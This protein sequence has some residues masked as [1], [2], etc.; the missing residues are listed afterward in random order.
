MRYRAAHA[1]GLNPGSGNEGSLPTVV[2]KGVPLLPVVKLGG[3]SPTGSENGGTPL[4][5]VKIGV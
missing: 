1:S 2:K 3:T 5:V 4:P